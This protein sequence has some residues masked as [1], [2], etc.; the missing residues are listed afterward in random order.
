MSYRAT[1]CSLD[2]IPSSKTS[3]SF[4]HVFLLSFL[5]KTLE[6]SVYN[7]LSS[8]LSE[9]DLLDPNQSGFR[10]G[11]STETA[12]LTVIESL[13]ATRVSSNSAVVIL[14]DL[15]SVFDT[16]NHQVLFSTVAELGI[17]D[18]V[19]NW[20]TSY[21][22]NLT[23]QVTWRSSLSKP[24]FLET[25]VPQGSVLGPLLFSIYTRSL[26]PAITS[27]GFSY[28]CYV[29]DTQLLLS[30]PPSSSNSQVEARISEC[31]ADI[32]FNSTLAKL[33]S[34][35]SR[36]TTALSW[37]CQSLSRMSRYRLHRWQGAWA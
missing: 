18:S 8:Y 12:L 9:N 28:H 33:N 29:D 16:V 3:N 24:C 36:G 22:T 31:L 1:T 5:S 27:H 2:P 4:R 26:G 10:S 15:S 34:S 6:H 17:A 11:H 7:Q 30:I 19:L 21:L 13:G 25:G 35:S 23:F 20:F 14:L 37:A 32:T